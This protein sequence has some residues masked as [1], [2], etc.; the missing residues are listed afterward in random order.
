LSPERYGQTTNIKNPYC[1]TKPNHI[2]LMKKIKANLKGEMGIGGAIGLGLLAVIIILG[3]SWAFTGNDFFLAKI[4]APKMEQVRHDTFK[5]SQA[6]N[7]GVA[8]QLQSFQFKYEQSNDEAKG[9]LAP[10]ILKYV[11]AYDTNKLPS[12]LQAFVSKLRRET[13][14]K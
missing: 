1:Q 12:E 5:G 4:F 7:D 9:A 3:L 2:Q 13:F 8:T 14:A 11:A 6:Y 10:I